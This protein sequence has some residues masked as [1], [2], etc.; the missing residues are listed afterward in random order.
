MNRPLR[1]VTLA[2]G[3]VNYKN[4]GMT[5]AAL[6]VVAP[7]KRESASNTGQLDH[8]SREHIQATRYKDIGGGF[9]RQR[10]GHPEGTLIVLQATETRRGTLY[11]EA[12]IFIRLREGAD[13]MSISACLPPSNESIIGNRVQIFVGE[14]DIL[15]PA[16]VRLLGI[17]VP[18]QYIQR[19]C[20]EEEVGELFEVS[21]VRAGNISKPQ[22]VAV[23]TSEGTVVKAV[24]QEAT[25]RINLRRRT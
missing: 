6:R 9:T 16:E 5:A 19:Y 10:V 14:G 21:V 3:K 23:A 11:S 4:S 7:F 22:L 24:G 18:R 12:C 13:M 1:R 25:R 2:Y 8:G 17:D 20:N 15:T